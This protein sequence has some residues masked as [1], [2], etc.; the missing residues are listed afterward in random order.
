MRNMLNAGYAKTLGVVI[1]AL[2]VTS[3]L[4]YLSMDSGLQ[5]P[6]EIRRVSHGA[7]FSVIAPPGWDHTVLFATNDANT[8]NA[9]RLIEGK[10]E[11]LPGFLNVVMSREPQSIADLR[12]RSYQP[13]E[14]AGHNA[15]RLAY[16]E[17]KMHGVVYRLEVNG[18]WYEVRLV[19][20]K[21]E[22][23]D[24]TWMAYLNSFKPATAST[25]APLVLHPTSV[26]TTLPAGKP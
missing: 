25:S 5:P 12:A 14:L 26:P 13:S 7:G 8:S 19:R 16:D 4:F 3:L 17:E 18:Q 6:A 24:E 21:V 9:I 1:V 23:I 2:V 15:W 22:A 10:S 20:P 11:T